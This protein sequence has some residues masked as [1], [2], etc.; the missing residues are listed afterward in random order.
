MASVKRIEA[1]ADCVGFLNGFHDPETRCYKNRNPGLCRAY[2]FAQLNSVD[3]DGYRIFTSNIGGIRFLHQDLTWKCSGQTRAKGENGKLKQTS[4]LTDLLKSFK[5][6]SI[7][8]LIQAV[9][10][11]NTAL[12]TEEITATTELKYFLEEGV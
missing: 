1:L 6:S 8:N 2:S 3:Q 12:Q 10:F 4:T 11:L 5:L 7:E 9:T